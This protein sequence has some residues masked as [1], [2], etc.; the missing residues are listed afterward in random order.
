MTYFIDRLNDAV[1][2]VHLRRFLILLC[3]LFVVEL[4][5]GFISHIASDD[6]R[7]SSLYQS[8]SPGKGEQDEIAEDEQSPDALPFPP[9]ASSRYLTQ[10]SAEHFTSELVVQAPYDR[11]IYNVIKVER[12]V[13]AEPILLVYIE[14]GQQVRMLLPPSK[15]RIKLARGKTWL[16]DKEL[17]GKETRAYRTNIVDLT[18]RRDGVPPASTTVALQGFVDGTTRG[19]M[20]IRKDQF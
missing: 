14:P 5:T 3:G 13:G 9:N 20:G 1:P 2:N 16:G 18:P 7:R 17:F 12:A 8:S 11:D 4:A 19:G 10:L 15:Y 6:P